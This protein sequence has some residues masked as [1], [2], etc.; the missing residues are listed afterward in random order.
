MPLKSESYR[1]LDLRKSNLGSLNVSISVP[2]NEMTLVSV[3]IT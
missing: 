2:S 1:T 3:K